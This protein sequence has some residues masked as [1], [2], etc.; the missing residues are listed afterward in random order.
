MERT[1][2]PK[3]GFV[4]LHTHTSASDGLNTPR[5]L[6]ALAVREGLC[7]IAITDHDTTSGVREALDAGKEQGLY[8]VPGCEISS[9]TPYGE[10]HIVGLWTPLDDP[11]LETALYRFRE[12]RKER[13]LAILKRLGEMGMPLSL[14]EVEGFANGESVGRPHIAAALIARGYVRSK[15]E[16]FE[17]FLAKNRAAYVPRLVDAPEEA[18]HLLRS[19][20]AVTVLAHPMLLGAP[21]AWIE[22]QAAM[23]KEYGLQAVEAYHSEHSLSDIRNCVTMAAR[24]GLALSGGSDFHGNERLGRSLGRGKGGLRIPV[25]VLHSLQALRS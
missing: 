15:E 8:I 17:R 3:F 19:V 10:M 7:A 14:G 16:A 18:V 23:L 12:R 25:S 5:E 2:L 1:L 9:M 24:L 20:G 22:Q 6:V 13:N 4:D 21:L 11:V